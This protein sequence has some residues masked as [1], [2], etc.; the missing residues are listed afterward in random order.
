MSNNQYLFIVG[1]PRSGTTYAQSLLATSVN[2]HTAPETHFFTKAWPSHGC[3]A[4]L[5]ALWT[6]IYCTKWL[7]TNKYP[8]YITP[9]LKRNRIADSFF[10]CVYG[11][12]NRN[13]V[14][15]EK[16]PAHLNEVSKIQR[17]FPNA[18]FIHV[19]RGF[20]NNVSSLVKAEKQWGGEANI[21]QVSARWMTER[22]KTYSYLLHSPERHTLV[23]YEDLIKNPKSSLEAALE[24]ISVEVDINPSEAHEAAKNVISKGESWK[25]NNTKEKPRLKNTS[26]NDLDCSGVIEK[27]LGMLKRDL[28]DVK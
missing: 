22:F 12:N 9:A 23:C 19:T 11:K 25:N 2:V 21:Y 14:L 6:Y 8:W 20:T 17:C 16:T 7:K 3:K 4:K 28:D 13:C 5:G 10:Q 26:I 15:L 18:K 1:T 27:A 24:S